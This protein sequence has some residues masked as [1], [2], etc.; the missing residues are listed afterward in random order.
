[1]CGIAGFADFQNLSNLDTLVKMT[2]TL[3]HR[4]PDDKGYLF[5]QKKNYQIGLGHSRLSVIDLS[6]GGHQP[7]NFQNLTI[8]YNGEI[9]NFKEIKKD[10]VRLGHS[11]V[12]E[13][14]TEVILHAYHQWGT[15]AIQRFIGMFSIVIWDESKEE[16]LIIR[17]RTGVKP[18]YYYWKDGVLLFGSELKSFIEHLSFKKAIN[19]KALEAYMH[20]GYIP[21]PL[22]IFQNAYKLKPGH[23]L[24][25]NLK[26]QKEYIYNYWTVNS[27]YS[28]PK[29]NLSYQDAKIELHE[30]LKNA[31]N[32]RMV[33]DVPV[34]IFLSGGYDSTAVAAILQQDKTERLKTFTIGFEEGN[35]EA[36]YAKA[37]AI[38]LDTDHSEL[39]CTTVEA[40]KIIPDLPYFF[41]E[42]F[43]DSSAIPTILVSRLAKINVKVALS[44]DASDEIFAGYNSY[45]LLRKNL[46]LINAIP[47]II[48]SP[49]KGITKLLSLLAPDSKPELAHKLLSVSKSISNDKFIQ[50]LCLINQMNQLPGDYVRQFFKMPPGE[51]YINSIEPAK[52]KE[53]LEIAMAMDYA[54][55]LPDDILT[56]VDR[57]TMSVSLEG[58]EPF[59]DHRILE[60]AAKLPIE[61]KFDG[62]TTKKILKDIVHEYIPFHMMNRPKTG[63]SLPINKWLRGE[64]NY[65]L[66]EY[67][68]EKTLSQSGLWN[69]K[70]I[71]SQIKL[72]K[73][74]KLHYTPIIW[75]ILM[76][77]MWLKQWMF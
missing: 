50:A 68:D 48:K 58:R 71:V 33:A 12:S 17:D 73:H 21:A 45:R 8:V 19:Q 51:I 63:F 16:L 9:Y 60:F 54:Y 38:H 76:F 10:L 4:G 5:K 42:P 2:N 32:Y 59:L 7:M 41:D 3:D 49:V 43:A 56:K 47:S 55:Y 57:A 36:S 75:R 29:S 53:P 22:T 28:L 14:D 11:F 31:F 67:L 1:M 30:L 74:D 27:F 46:I 26:T 24:V 69:E 20:Y 13:S 44:A 40:Q 37:T 35:N 39:I 77:Q 18:L 52:F 34:G 66:D 61:Y 72:F 15:D 62:K 64:L 70:F 65:L 25:F 6:M 23:W